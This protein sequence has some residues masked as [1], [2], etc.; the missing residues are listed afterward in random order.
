M[1]GPYARWLIAFMPH[2][3]TF[4]HWS[5]MKLIRKHVSA[6]LICLLAAKIKGLMVSRVD[7]T[8]EPAA[9]TFDNVKPE[10]L[11][12]WS[13]SIIVK[14]CLA[15][16]ATTPIRYPALLLRELLTAVLAKDINSGRMIFRHGSKPLFSIC[17]QRPAG[18][19]ALVGLAA[20]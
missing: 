2:E 4:R 7:S 10:S 12:C 17:V 8:P 9:I 14:A 1:I 5:A 3:Q 19:T 6:N 18:V 15:T 16:I 13:A 20:L 11:F